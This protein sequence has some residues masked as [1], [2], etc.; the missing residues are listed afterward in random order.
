MGFFQA[1]GAGLAGAGLGFLVGGPVGALAGAGIGLFASAYGMSGNSSMGTWGGAAI[2]GLAGFA[3]GG[4]VGMLAGGLLGGQLSQSAPGQPIEYTAHG[5]YKVCVN[6]DKV[7]ITDPTGKHN[8]TEWGDAHERV[9]GKEVGQ[10]D[11]KTRS[12]LLSDGARVSMQAPDGH[13]V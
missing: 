13:S 7:S 3:I 9:G 6:G 4:P 11:D 12:I 1:I 2:G 8:V 5:G 10:W